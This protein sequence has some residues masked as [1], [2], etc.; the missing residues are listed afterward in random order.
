MSR[1]KLK[2]KPKPGD[3]AKNE[4]KA[5]VMIATYDRPADLVT[6][7]KHVRWRATLTDNDGACYQT[8]PWSFLFM[9]HPRLDGVK[10]ILRGYLLCTDTGQFTDTL[11]LAYPVKIDKPPVKVDE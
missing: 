3:Y 2:L 7:L 8:L 4:F 11:H 5:G 6:A 1:D 9:M 10:S